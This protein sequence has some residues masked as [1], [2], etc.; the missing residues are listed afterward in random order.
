V[1]GSAT[2]LS[3]V[4]D[5]LPCYQRLASRLVQGAVPSELA[6]GAQRLLASHYLNVAR[7][8]LSR[9]DIAGATELVLQPASR[10][11]PVYFLRTLA[12]VGMSHLGRMGA[13]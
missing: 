4:S 2:H 8:R 11:N 5:L 1:I 7:A 12:L 6:A 13:K 3:R 10:A 9:N